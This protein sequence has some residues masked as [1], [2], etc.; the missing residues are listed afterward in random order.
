MLRLRLD[1][2]LYE[3]GFFDSREKAQRAVLAGQVLVEGQIH[4][5][6]GS[7]IPET[8]TITITERERYVSRGGY[9]LEGALRAFAIDPTGLECLDLGSS[10]GGF[11]DCLLQHGA[12]H[13][14]GIDVGRGQLAWSLRQDPRVTIREGINARY[15]QPS[16]FKNLFDLIV[17]DLS[18]IS[19]T[20][21][22]PSAFS[23]IKPEG[24]IIVLIKPQFELSKKEVGRGGIVRDPLLHQKAIDSIRDWVEN[25]GHSF[26]NVTRSPLPGTTGNIEFL[27]LLRFNI[28]S[29]KIAL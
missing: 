4:S 18:F 28:P 9:K 1:Q 23:L 21:I 15:L 27:A 13:V 19:L 12:A 24:H 22:L 20:R 7:K 2:L 29:L 8:S 10:T 6:P 17:G 3:K 5:K 25:A 11:T 16:D 14:T 26:E